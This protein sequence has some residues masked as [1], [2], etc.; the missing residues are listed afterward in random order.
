MFKGLQQDF[1]D[2]GAMNKGERSRWSPQKNQEWIMQHFTGQVWQALGFH[3]NC[4][5]ELPKDFEY[6]T[7]MIIKI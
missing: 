7:H 4:D 2:Q 5:I 6:N 3:A 1:W